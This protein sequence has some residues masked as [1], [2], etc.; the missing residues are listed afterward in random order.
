MMILV[1][2]ALICVVTVILFTFLLW[3]RNR[4]R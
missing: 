4:L 1:D 3:M 2:F